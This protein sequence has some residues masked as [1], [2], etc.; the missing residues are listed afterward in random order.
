MRLVN[1]LQQKCRYHSP[2]LGG[3]KIEGATSRLGVHGFHPDALGI[4]VL[5]AA[6]MRKSDALTT[7]KNNEFGLQFRK[8]V[9]ML[10][11]QS[12]KARAWP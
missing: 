3:Q 2:A 7:A 4:Q 1:G 11:Q 8:Q 10:R 12:L 5:Q 6:W 9:E